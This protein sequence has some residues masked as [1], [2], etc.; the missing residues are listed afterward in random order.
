[1]IEN[2]VP[3]TTVAPVG[4]L[5]GVLEGLA[6]SVGHLLSRAA[7]IPREQPM[8]TTAAPAYSEAVYTASTSSAVEVSLTPLPVVSNAEA[9]DGLPIGAWIGIGFAVLFILI[10]G[11]VL[12][13]GHKKVTE[14]LVAKLTRNGRRSYP[15]R[16]SNVFQLNVHPLP[17]RTCSEHFSKMSQTGT[18]STPRTVAPDFPFASIDVEPDGRLSPRLPIPSKRGSSSLPGT[19]NNLATM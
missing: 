5:R 8:I 1:M 17:P 12:F 3:L 7:G 13:F 2:S 16:Q 9:A 14:Y 18:M 11:V 19:P 4:H 10:L 6:R 15:T